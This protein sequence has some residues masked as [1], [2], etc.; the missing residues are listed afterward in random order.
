[1]LDLDALLAPISED[2]PTGE[3]LSFSIEFD[4][5]QEFRRADDP[6]LDQGEWQTEIK[7]ADWTGVL[8]ECSALLQTR[9]KDLR[10]AGWLAEA[11]AQIDGYAG[12][13]QGYRL[14]AGLC[15]QYWEQVHPHADDGDQEER[16]GNLSWLLSNSLQWLR[17]VPIVSA[18]QGRFSLN[19]FE[20][21]HS[22]QG[23]HDTDHEGHPSLD[24]L[25]AA[26]H[27][28]PPEFYR[29]L[30]AAL[31]DCGQALSALQ[32]AVDERL[33]LDGPSFS[34]VRERI[35]HLQRTVQRFARESGLL[36]DG[37]VAA[38]DASTGSNSATYAEQ[39]INSAAAAR[40]PAGAPGTRR[41]ALAQLR[42]VAD[43]FRRT[44]P[45]SPVAYLAEKAARWGEMPLHVWLRRVIK[46][47][48]VLNQME[49]MLD[50]DR[51]VDGQ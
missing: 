43:F 46:D 29:Q 39:E 13:A 40:G 14:M 17:N 1:M 36:L 38:D 31:P 4:R 8:R 37:E 9:T 11:S 42:Q 16:I 26:R 3:D 2:A 47:D 45:H 12:L 20:A 27:D 5:I 18:P 28:T 7:Y 35:E 19:D 25:E 15:Q 21:A 24:Q 34:A 6:T 41:E 23:Q 44:E 49:E 33:G 10:L 30:L 32:A 51:N 50:I 22:R 48:M